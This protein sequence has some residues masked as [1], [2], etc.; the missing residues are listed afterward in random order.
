M[1]T[2][3]ASGAVLGPVETGGSLVG[4][5]S[6]ADLRAWTALAA[7]E[8]PLREGGVELS[9]QVPLFPYPHPS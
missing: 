4:G 3:L 1:V 9:S 5:G 6:C 7:G 2:L 8:P